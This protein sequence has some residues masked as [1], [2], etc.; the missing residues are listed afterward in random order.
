MWPRRAQ[1]GPKP[2][3]LSGRGDWSPKA[4]QTARAP[5]GCIGLDRL[6]GGFK[7]QSSPE[8]WLDRYKSQTRLAHTHNT[9]TSSAAANKPAIQND[10]AGF[11][12]PATG[13]RT[14]ETLDLDEC[15]Q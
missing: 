14:V 8:H 1:E 11:T 3:L 13:P 2:V 7:S 15:V 9:T 12:F 5:G 4:Q 6:I 10:Y